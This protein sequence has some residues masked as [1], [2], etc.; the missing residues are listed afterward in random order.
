MKYKSIFDVYSRKKDTIL[1]YQLCKAYLGINGGINRMVEVILL[2]KEKNPFHRKKIS[3]VVRNLVGHRDP[4]IN[5]PKLGIHSKSSQILS[6]F[7]ERNFD[8]IVSSHKLRKGIFPIKFMDLV[9]EEL[10]KM[11]KNG[12]N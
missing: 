9:D 2:E 3:E 5:I 10:P 1:D 8:R 12:L 11:K 6:D 4:L 7:V